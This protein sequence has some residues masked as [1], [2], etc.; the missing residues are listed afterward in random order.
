[1][2]TPK[3]PWYRY[4]P[5][6]SLDA[7]ALA[8]GVT[9]EA[10][11]AARASI[12]SSYRRQELP[13]KDGGVRVT[14]S[15]AKPLKAIQKRILHCILRKADMPDYLLGG[16]PG[17]SYLD[18]VQY[19]CG[20]K[21]L[22]GEDVSS[23]YPS[24]KR[25]RVHSIFQHLFHFPP[26]VAECLADLCTYQGEVPQ[27]APPSGDLAN[28]A[29]WRREPGLVARFEE[30]GF[31][32]SRYVDDVY[33]SAPRLISS[34]DKTW[35]V[36]E[37]LALLKLEG[38]QV[39]RTKHELATSR[40]AMRVHRV[41][42]NAG[43]PSISKKVRSKLRADVHRLMIACSLRGDEENVRRMCCSLRGRAA[44]LKRLHPNEYARLSSQLDV[45]ESAM[46]RGKI[47]AP[48]KAGQRPS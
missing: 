1:M 43:R 48:D 8:L 12:A 31:R 45:A 26:E 23:F 22:F 35:I 14:Y 38:F 30:K 44:A 24:I 29:L 2:Q 9:K 17:R 7:L 18:N 41:G 21:V 3:V 20:A 28:L 47:A 10:I 5:I 15:V 42:I 34:Q 32:Y 37:I 4:A 11:L 6:A 13:K 46:Q 39:K 16:R 25:V 36:G 33:V 27:G 19:H 40:S